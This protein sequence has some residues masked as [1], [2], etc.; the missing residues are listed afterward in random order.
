MLGNIMKKSAL[1]GMLGAALVVLSAGTSHAAPTYVFDATTTSN[2][3]GLTGYATLGDMMSGMLVTANFSGG[4]SETKSWAATGVGAGGVTGT[5]WSLNQS[6]DTFVSIGVPK[7]SG[8]GTWAF[9]NRRTD[10]LLSL[11]LNGNPG[12]TIFDV[13]MYSDQTTCDTFTATGVDQ[14]CSPGSARGSR[15]QSVDNISPLVTYSDVVSIGSNPP[16]GDL[17]H[18]MTVDFGPNGIGGNFTFNQDT[19]NDSRFNVPEPTA[20][21]LFGLAFAALGVARRK[22]TSSAGTSDKVT[23]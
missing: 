16:F 18:V 21:A 1:P 17:Y 11:V 12:L 13:D 22:S 8:A 7:G 4:I 19:D 15:F 14:V 3:P 23:G 6:G 2:I 9:T 5:D 10:T 20:L